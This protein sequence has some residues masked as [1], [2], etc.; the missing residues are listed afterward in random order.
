MSL[1]NRYIDQGIAEIV[2]RVLFTD[3]VYMLDIECF[4]FLNRALESTLSPI[5][6]FATNR[7]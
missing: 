1:V 5:V 6:V 2:P 4:L 3:E 7:E